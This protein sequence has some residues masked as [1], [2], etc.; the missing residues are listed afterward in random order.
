MRHWSE[1][2]KGLF[3][4]MKD[5]TLEEPKPLMAYNITKQ[6]SEVLHFLKHK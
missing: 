6:F 4:P 2:I 1:A 3:L 5:Y